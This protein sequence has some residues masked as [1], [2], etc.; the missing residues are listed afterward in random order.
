MITAANLRS[1]TEFD[2]RKGDGDSVLQYLNENHVAGELQCSSV[3]SDDHVQE[4]ERVLSRNHSAIHLTSLKLPNNGLTEDSSRALANILRAQVETLRELDL[5]QNPLKGSGLETLMDSLV[6]DHPPSRLHSLNLT[7]TMLGVQGATAIASLLN[8]N[9]SLKELNLSSNNLGTRGVK[10]IAPALQ[11]NRS[12]ESLNLSSNKINSKGGNVIAKAIECSTESN[13]KVL[14]MSSNKIGDAGIQT[15]AK[16]LTMDKKIEGFFAGCTNIGPEGAL[17]LATVLEFNY[18]LRHLKLQGNQIGP[19]GAKFLL[20]GLAKNQSTALEKF[21]LSYNAIGVEGAAHIAQ[22]LKENPKLTHL[23]L[24]GNGI[25]SEGCQKIAEALTYNLSLRELTLTN[26]QIENSGAFSLAMAL[27]KPT[28]GLDKLDWKENPIAD[29]G[30]VALGRVPQ[31]RK[32]HEHWFGKMLRDLAKGVLF[33]VNLTQKKIGDEEI[34]FLT[35]VLSDHNPLIRSFW[36]N[37]QALSARSLV[38]LFERTL[39]SNARIQRLYLKQCNVG[40]DVAAALGEALR[41]NVT[42]EVCSLTNC[43]ISPKGA[44]EIA[45]GLKFN[46]SLRRLNLDRNHIQDDGFTNLLTILP[47]PTLTALSACYNQITDECMSFGTLKNLDELSLN[48]NEISDRGAVRLCEALMDDCKLNRLCLRSNDI[49]GRGSR[50]IQ[51]FLPENAI[52]EF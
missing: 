47:H 42:L 36:L 4:L 37:G 18:R 17:H 41:R 10:I 26:N 29:E 48:G 31:L 6:H 46:S 9:T 44:A 51:N 3:L 8:H 21:D 15:F 7:K 11:S 25:G 52:F 20:E 39:S 2:Q 22:A 28:C 40:D 50:A 38:P 43:S 13:L 27:G 30:L 14:D 32:N 33:S 12:L 5:S 35:D 24:S 34:L 19:V 45:E 1:I 23:N 16:L 49:S